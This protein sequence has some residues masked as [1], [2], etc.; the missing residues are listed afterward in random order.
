MSN[1]DLLVAVVTTLSASYATELAGLSKKTLG[2]RGIPKKTQEAMVGSFT[3]GVRSC[4]LHLR[5]TDRVKEG[6]AESPQSAL[7]RVMRR[8]FVD[9]D[10]ER[11]D[12][13]ESPFIA[14]IDRVVPR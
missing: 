7:L 10:S 2:S 1:N 14:A 5:R 12:G 13:H 8:Y 9:L 11:G 4:F 6:A 3:D